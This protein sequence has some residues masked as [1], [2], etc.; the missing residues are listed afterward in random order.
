[1]RKAR[2]VA[3]FKIQKFKNSKI[4]NADLTPK[5]TPQPCNP[6]LIMKFRFGDEPNSDYDYKFMREN[7]KSKFKIQIKTIV[8]SRLHFQAEIKPHI[9]KERLA[10]TQ[11]MQETTKM[12]QKRTPDHSTSKSQINRG[13]NETKTRKDETNNREREVEENSKRKKKPPN[14]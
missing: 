6:G 2:R 8:K 12:A 4:Q 14:S 9:E 3:K 11:T 13:E 7:K 1:M 10:K 5:K